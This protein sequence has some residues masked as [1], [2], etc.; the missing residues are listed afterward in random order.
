MAKENFRMLDI[1][2][3][4]TILE[5]GRIEE[6]TAEPGKNQS[7]VENL[8]SRGWYSVIAQFLLKLEIPP[9]LSSSQAKTIKLRATKYCTHENLLYWRDP[10]GILLRC[11]DKEQSMEVMQQFH[12]SMCGGHHYWKTTAHKILRAGGQHKWILV[13]TDYFTKWIKA[14]PTRKADHRVVMK[15]LT[16][17]IFTKFG[18]PHKLITDNAAAFREKELVDMCD[19]MGIKLVHTTSY[20]PQGNGLAES[21][22]KSLTRIIKKLL[23][24]NKKNWDSKLKYA[25]CADRV[26][27]KKSTGNSPFK[28]VY[29]TE[30]VFPIKLNLPVA[31][32]LQEEKNEEEDM[33][34][35]NH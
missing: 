15:F 32:F 13:A 20:Y 35:K 23:E 29:G 18:F 25:L 1:N 3:M 9:D 28:L 6:E 24:D 14:I 11:L 22:N 30:A 21:S 31:R 2:L 33:A 16:E 10:F 17:N 26:T 4:S 12:S 8:T 27:I 7:L 5:N 34:K 19:S